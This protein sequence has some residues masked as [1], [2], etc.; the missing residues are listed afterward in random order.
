M[1]AVK[2]GVTGA[3][4]SI[5]LVVSTAGPASAAPPRKQPAA[6][7]PAAPAAVLVAAAGCALTV[8]EGT[9]R[10]EIKQRLREGRFARAEQI[11]VSAAVDCAFGAVPG[12]LLA[13]R[14]DPL[15]AAVIRLVRPLVRKVLLRYRSKI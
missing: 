12:G 5:A 13:K 3:A 7:A 1:A 14:L 11:A 10:D 15:R 8:L 9:A 6:A 4:L 2:T